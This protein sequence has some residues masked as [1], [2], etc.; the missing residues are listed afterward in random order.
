[1]ARGALSGRLAASEGSLSRRLNGLRLAG[2]VAARQGDRQR[3]RLN[4]RRAG[5]TQFGDTALHGFGDV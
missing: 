4:G 1:M 3:L 5:K 2:H